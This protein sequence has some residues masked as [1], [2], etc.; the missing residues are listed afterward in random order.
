MRSHLED[1]EQDYLEK[2]EEI[3]IYSELM[4]AEVNLFAFQEMN[5]S[6]G[7]PNKPSEA[8]TRRDFMRFLMATL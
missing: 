1:W 6:K 8:Q 5:R 4:N 3:G 2:L 7:T